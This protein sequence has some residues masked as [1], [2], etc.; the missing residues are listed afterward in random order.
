MA[1]LADQPGQQPVLWQRRFQDMEDIATLLSRRS[2]RQRQISLTQLGRGPIEVDLLFLQFHQVQVLFTSSTGP[3]RCL[4]EKTQGYFGFSM[5]LQS[6]GQGITAHGAEVREHTLFGLD[7]NRGIDMVVPH[8]LDFC[9]V[10][11][12]KTL[13]DECLQIM[14]RGDL[15][16]RLLGQNLFHSPVTLPRVAAYLQ[17][18]RSLVGR[19]TPPFPLSHL[20][21]FIIKDFI[22]LLIDAISPVQEPFPSPVTT[23]GA[24]HRAQLVRQAEEYI[25][26]RLDHPLTL[27]DLCRVLHTSKSPLFQSFQSVLGMG[28][29]AYLK[30]QRLHAVR[31]HLKVADPATESV[32]ATA[33]RFGFWSPGHFARDYQR[34]FGERPSATLLKASDRQR[35]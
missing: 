18:L 12:S 3:V 11:I 15:E 17:Q 7:P 30:I 25:L 20:E 27:Q 26:A 31:R 9:N 23:N 34:L 21:S 1:N 24:N 29:M 8:H 35:P 32:T 4:G 2:L 19:R 10:N 6:H 33:H 14:D 16:D 28:P 5:V 13:F 22:P